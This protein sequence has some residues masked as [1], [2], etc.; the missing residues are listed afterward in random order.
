MQAGERG[1]P[2]RSSSSSWYK[3]LLSTRSEDSRVG[4]F[5]AWNVIYRLQM[6]SA[7]GGPFVI[8]RGAASVESRADVLHVQNIFALYE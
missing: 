6:I 3:H 5:S 2:G 7:S 8:R 4:L 1:R